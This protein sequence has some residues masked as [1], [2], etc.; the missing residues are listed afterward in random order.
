[1]KLISKLVLLVTVSI[2]I[3]LVPFGTYLVMVSPISELNTEFRILETLNVKSLELRIATSALIFGPF[4]QQENNFRS[5]LA[6]YRQALADIARIQLIPRTSPELK[7]SFQAIVNLQDLSQESIQTIL[8]DLAL[9]DRS[10]SAQTSKQHSL[11]KYLDY[12]YVGKLVHPENVDLYI[13][14]LINDIADTRLVMDQTSNVVLEQNDLVSQKIEEIRS[15]GL[16]LST[17]LLIVAIGASIL[18]SYLFA[19][20]LVRS[21]HVIDERIIQLRQEQFG[22]APAIHRNDEIGGVAKNLDILEGRLMEREQLRTELEQSLELLHRTQSEMILAG[23]MAAIGSLVVGV[24]HE[25]NTPIG[26][27]VT[28]S[29]YLQKV[30]TDEQARLEPSQDAGPKNPALLQTIGNATEMILRSL[31]RAAELIN[32]LKTVP[33]N[34]TEAVKTFAVHDLMRDTLQSLAPKLKPANVSITLQVPP[35]LTI[36]SHPEALSQLITQLVTNS[37]RHGFA[38][39]SGGS[40]LIDCQRQDPKDIVMTYQ[41]D[42]VGLSPEKLAHIFEPFFKG[43]RMTEGFGL[44]TFII[45]SLVAFRFSGKVTVSSDEGHGLTY[46]I[47][48]PDVI[49]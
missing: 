41:D 49:N 3:F 14:T 27:G 13:R 45:Y 18:L 21:I 48:L 4:D 9:I 7:R 25:L 19:Y 12:Y 32:M 42:G 2:I 16:A 38:G 20:N 40:I 34:A 30:V 26:I 43:Q 24:A 37:L 8:R 44:G 29:S 39:R 35:D 17:L 6:A 47:E 11:V 23:K 10:L 36:R 46:H 1:M 31:N 5:A 15:S 28:A 33:I 22:L